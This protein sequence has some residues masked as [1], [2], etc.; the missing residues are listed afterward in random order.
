MKANI[1]IT[2]YYCYET[3]GETER[4][5]VSDALN[6]FQS[7]MSMPVASFWYDDIDIEEIEVEEE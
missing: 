3:E 5:C 7:E 1:T 6:Q 4:D 2:R